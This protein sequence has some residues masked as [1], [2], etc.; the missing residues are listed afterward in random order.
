[1]EAG[2]LER[3]PTRALAH[4]LIGALDEG[5]MVI[6][7]ADDAD[8][9]RAEVGRRPSRPPRRAARVARTGRRRLDGLV[10]QSTQAALGSRRVVHA[11]RPAL[12]EVMVM[13]G[14]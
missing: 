8:A 5:A 13:S 9:A 6:A 4:V 7:T 11:E 1:M 3:R 14:G 2:Q 12:N 10:A